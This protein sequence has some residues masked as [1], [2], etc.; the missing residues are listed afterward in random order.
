MKQNSEK[1]NEKLIRFH[2]FNGSSSSL[3]SIRSENENFN[4]KIYTWQVTW[5]VCSI[6][7][8]FF[9]VIRFQKYWLYLERILFENSLHLIIIDHLFQFW[10]FFFRIRFFFGNFSLSHNTKLVYNVSSL[11]IMMWKYNVKTCINQSS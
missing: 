5:L 8:P 3:F 6:Y 2:G 4:E 9:S 11:M 7:F 1:I 10:K